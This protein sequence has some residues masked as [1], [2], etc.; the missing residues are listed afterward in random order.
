MRGVA[1]RARAAGVARAARQRDDRRR[2][3]RGQRRR[4]A[5]AGRRGRRRI[6]GAGD[7]PRP[8][9][10][11]RD[12]PRARA[13]PAQHRRRPAAR[14]HDGDHR[15]VGFG[16]E[17]AGLRRAVQRRPAPLPGV[18]QRL[19]AAV[20]AAAAA[21]RRRRDLRHPADRGDRPAHQP[22]RAQEHGGHADRSA[23]VHETGLRQ[24]RHA[25]LPRLRG[26]DRTSDRAGHRRAAAARAARQQCRRDGAAGRAAQGR[27]HRAG[28]VGSQARPQPPVG[29]RRVPA[30][31]SVAAPRSLPRARHRAAAGRD[32]HRARERGPAARTGARGGAARQGRGADRR[33][34]GPAAPGD[35]R[36]R[37]DRRPCRVAAAHLQ[38]APRLPE[39]RAQF[40]RAR[41]APVL[42]QLAGRLV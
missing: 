22:R 33:P 35:G 8:R 19:R 10:L 21:T 27:L 41:P 14:G 25:V 42:V 32:R 1:H 7:A 23:S 37:R 15:R 34:A 4:G 36:R 30:D 24:A 26:A 31:R 39:L 9:G 16:Q 38:H 11:H 20:R 2:A 29:R 3:R 5:A 13:Q 28:A 17:L 12:P 6:P 40:R 18:D